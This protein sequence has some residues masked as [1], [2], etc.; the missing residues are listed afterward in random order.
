[1]SNIL[2]L[3]NFISENSKYEN[4]VLFS[5]KLYLDIINK[6]EFMNIEVIDGEYYNVET[7]CLKGTLKNDEKVR[8]HIPMHVDQD[9]DLTWYLNYIFVL[10]A[11]FFFLIIL[12]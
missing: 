6:N 9:L 4:N 3:E 1:M 11:T 10:I 8:V 5:Y 2:N 12:F 7:Y